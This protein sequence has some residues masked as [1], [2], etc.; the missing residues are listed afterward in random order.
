MI[1]AEKP[2]GESQRLEVLKSYN[3][4]DTLPEEAYDTA[5]R[6]AAQICNTP[7][8]LVT[9]L[10]ADRNFLKSRIGVDITESPRNISFCSHAILTKEPIFVVEDARLDD[11]FKNNPLVE[12]FKAI[13]Y[14]GVPLRNPE[15]YALGTLC[16]YDHK[17]RVLSEEQKDALRDLAKQVVLLFEAHRKNNDLIAIQEELEKRNTRLEDFSRLVAH[18]LKSPLVS[19]E[20]LLNLV[21]EDFPQEEGTDLHMYLKHLDTSAKSMRNYIDGLLAYYK[22]DE[23]I[24]NKENTTLKEIVEDVKHLHQANDVSIELINN[25]N[26]TNISKVAVEQ[27]ITNLVDNAIKYNNDPNPTV[28]ISSQTDHKHF[29]ITLADNGVGIPEN[30]RELIFELFKTTGTKD[31][32]GNKGSGMGLATV[33]KLVNALGGEISVSS[34]PEGGSIFTFSIR[35]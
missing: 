24:D 15:G 11:R 35:R 34:N 21:R 3:L 8:S 33:K 13:F 32:F 22:S 10:D 7:I 16:V 20:G 18:D 2:I 5:T 9:L 4:L 12:E 28:K 14:A 23:L 17:P 29:I 6:L 27:I 19:M 25:M 1:E 26:L 30:K 31:R